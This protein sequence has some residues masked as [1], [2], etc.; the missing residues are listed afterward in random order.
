[1]T[2][3]VEEKKTNADH[4]E[5]SAAA[6]EKAIRWVVAQAPDGAM[7]PLCG[8]KA[9]YDSKD[10]GKSLF[11]H[12]RSRHLYKAIAAFEHGDLDYEA[13]DQ[14]ADP[15][16]QAG[17]D[18]GDFLG[19]YDP[20]HLPVALKRKVEA[21][22]SK[23]RLVSSNNVQRYKD[24]GFELVKAPDDAAS[25]DGTLRVNELVAMK[26][27][28]RWIERREAIKKAKNGDPIATR[29]E[30]FERR[31]EEHARNVY[32]LAVRK[33]ASAGQARNLARAVERGLATGTITSRR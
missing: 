14:D 4:T 10:K 6:I 5:E 1:M 22:G 21:D 26:V 8:W 27:P 2:E 32:D 33:G 7:C 30:D 19:D 11:D 29:K 20:L 12:V 16:S 13:P 18:V 3:Q 31:M 23:I 15:V 28:V 17:L 9:A 25:E 24:L